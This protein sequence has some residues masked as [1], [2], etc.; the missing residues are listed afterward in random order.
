MSLFK[1]YLFDLDGTLLDTP[2][3]FEKMFF[4][5]EW[6]TEPLT[7]TAKFLCGIDTRALLDYLLGHELGDIRKH[8]EYFLAYYD[9]NL[10]RFTT[11]YPGAIEL[12]TE[13]KQNQRKVGIISNKE[14]HF[15]E[16]INEL[17]NLDLDIMLG[18]GVLGY[19]K[20]HPAPLLYG[21]NQ[22]ELKPYE[23]IYVGDMPTDLRASHLALMH[24]V[25]ARYGC[26]LEFNPHYHYRQ[27]VD[28]VS[29]ISTIFLHKTE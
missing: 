8:H 6:I 13:I 5:L 29:E 12:L 9:K 3:S 17:F 20:P 11:F 16:K 4:E 18:S 26:Y 24:G 21:A 7:P 23:C 15:C 28:S 19:K 27:E 25:F 1:G 22:L 14:H 10:D 2:T